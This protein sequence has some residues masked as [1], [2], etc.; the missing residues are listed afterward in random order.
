MAVTATVGQLFLTLAFGGGAPAKVSVVGLSQI[1]TG[2]AFDAYLWGREVNAVALLGTA[3]VIA[4][5]AWLLVREASRGAAP[6][7]AD[8]DHT[9]VPK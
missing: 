8:A 3:L 4:P 5:T 2:L 1:V 9:R 7:L 6:G